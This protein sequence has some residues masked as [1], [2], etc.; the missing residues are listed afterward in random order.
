MTPNT[1]HGDFLYVILCVVTRTTQKLN[2]V[3]GCFTYQIIALLSEIS[4]LWVRAVC[5]V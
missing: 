1:H 5:R 4:I 3:L 2:V